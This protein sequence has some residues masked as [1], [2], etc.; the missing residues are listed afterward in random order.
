LL[1][2]FFIFFVYFLQTKTRRNK[3]KR[4]VRR[5]RR[6]TEKEKGR[7]TFNTKCA[8]SVL[9]MPIE[10]QQIYRMFHTN[11]EHH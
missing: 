11:N 6:N 7:A 9:Q 1:K 2:L 10:H 5:K 4:G 8:A 3:N